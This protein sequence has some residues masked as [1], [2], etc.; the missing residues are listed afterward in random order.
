[1]FRMSARRVF[2]VVFCSVPL[3]AQQI[4]EVTGYVKSPDGSAV[5]NAAVGFD[6][7]DYKAHKEVKSDKK[8]SYEI[9]TLL[10]GDYSVTVTV[11]GK[12]RAFKD[13]YHIDPGRQG[14]PLT[15]IL[16]QAGEPIA[17]A[18][19][20]GA[21]QS[22]KAA[23]LTKAFE[24]GKAAFAAADFAK[25]IDSLKQAAAID[26]KQA[27]VWSLLADC[28]LGASEYEQARAAFAKAIELAPTDA[29]LY[30]AWAVSLGR[31]GKLDEAKQ[32]LAKAIQLDP[33]GAGKYYYNLGVLLLDSQPGDA[34]DAFH[35]AIEADPK[36]AEAQY[37]YGLALAMAAKQGPDGKLAAPPGAIEALQKYLELTPSGPNAKTARDMLKLFGN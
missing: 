19:R 36:Y 21:P 33:R 1:M 16:K 24:A 13:F 29:A 22:D 26:P 2:W 7:L 18:E 28:Y 17:L 12:I 11:D 31:A 34:V 30:N 15:F 5:A 23:E 32:N 14:L 37:Q 9:H 8:G 3:L 20:T 35:H 4:G 6:R 10:P 25:G 27:G